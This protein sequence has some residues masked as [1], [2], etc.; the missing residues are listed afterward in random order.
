M[1]LRPEAEERR[2]LLYS[3]FKDFKVKPTDNLSHKEVSLICVEVN[4]K[5]AEFDPPLPRYLFDI[6]VAGQIVGGIDLRV[7]YSIEYY[8][9]GQ[10][11][12]GIEEPFRGNGYST[13]ACF[14]LLPLLKSHGFKRV[15]V[16]TDENNIASRRSCEKIGASFIETVDTPK[17]S[18]LYEEG[19]RRTSIYEWILE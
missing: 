16:T 18:V 11:G 9:V 10:I 7:G 17:W 5:H 6:V 19:Q 3:P 4:P 1:D 2:K 14:A 8:L 13:K 12:Y 15:L